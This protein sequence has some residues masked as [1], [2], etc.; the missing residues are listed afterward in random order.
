MALVLGHDKKQTDLSC[1]TSSCVNRSSFGFEIEA[2][3]TKES[4]EPG[5]INEVEAAVLTGSIIGEKTTLSHIQSSH[6]MLK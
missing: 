3:T 6:Y 2:T 1:M 5:V 4:R